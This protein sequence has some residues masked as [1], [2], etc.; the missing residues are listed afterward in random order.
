MNTPEKTAAE[1]YRE[2]SAREVAE[3][4]TSNDKPAWLT[5]P[6]KVKAPETRHPCKQCGNLV[7]NGRRSGALDLSDPKRFFCTLRC[8][9]DMGVAFVNYLQR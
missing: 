5:A 9:A 8:A 2:R 3:W 6:R 1:K 7:D 4:E